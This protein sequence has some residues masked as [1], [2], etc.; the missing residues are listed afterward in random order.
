MMRYVAAFGPA[1][2][3]DAATWSR[4]NGLR[5]VF[6]RLRPSLRTYRDDDGREY[7]DVPDDPLPDPE[8][9]A[10]V[11]LLPQYD[12]VLLSHKDRSRFVGG[13]LAAMSSIWMG[14][15]GFVGSVLV[16][17]T[18]A[19]MWRIDAPKRPSSAGPREPSRMTI[20][21][22]RRL[23]EVVEAEVEG[24]ASRFLQFATPGV[25]HAVRFAPIA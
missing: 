17:G 5:E 14:Q 2:V 13:D 11:R 12:N 15:L 3:Q 19:G 9:P 7:F 24:E 21:T 23:T 1:T 20:T 10:P 16:D 18:L 4:Y 25:D 8:T 22:P 6:D